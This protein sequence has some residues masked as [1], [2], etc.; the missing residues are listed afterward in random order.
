MQGQHSS[1]IVLMTDI[2]RHIHYF[3]QYQ[4]PIFVTVQCHDNGKSMFRTHRWTVA[5]KKHIDHRFLY[6]FLDEWF[7]LDTKFYTLIQGK[8]DRI[9]KY[10]KTEVG[11]KY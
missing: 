1:S 5:F 4:H 9:K 11:I 2:D 3:I 10:I 6:Y 8:N 7:V